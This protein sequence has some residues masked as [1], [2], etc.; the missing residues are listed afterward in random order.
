MSR[1]RA[2]ELERLM[3]DSINGRI[4]LSLDDIRE[5]AYEDYHYGVLST[6]SYVEVVRRSYKIACEK[7]KE[8]EWLKWQKNMKWK[9]K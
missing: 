4:N 1:K 8:R 9:K 6:S 3:K 7:Y 5:I 2:L